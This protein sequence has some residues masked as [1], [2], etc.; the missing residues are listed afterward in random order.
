MFVQEKG[1]A[2]FTDSASSDFWFGLNAVE[3]FGIWTWTDGTS[4]DFNDWDNGQPKNTSDTNCG[5]VNL[6][7]GKWNADNC[8]KEKPFVCMVNKNAPPATTT[9][10]PI[11]CLDTWTYY[12]TTG[13]CYKA[14]D[15]ATFLD[16]EDRCKISGA[17]LASIHNQNENLF[18]ANL[19]NYPGSDVCDGSYQA[20]IGLFREDIAGRWQWAD[21]TIYD[22]QNWAVGHPENGTACNFGYMDVTSIC[23]EPTGRFRTT[24]INRVLAKYVCKKEP[25]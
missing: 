4:F 23:N 6:E 11:K 24:Y 20:F 22:Y 15:N 7:S 13:Y 17:H 18:A 5:A 9:I 2:N 3:N 25:F 12:P 1:T 14:F 16:A 8:N 21:G 10:K 19:A